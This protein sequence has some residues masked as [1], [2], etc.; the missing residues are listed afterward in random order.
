MSSLHQRAAALT[1]AAVALLAPQA[2][3]DLKI[4]E[5]LQASLEN[6][7]Q[8]RIAG[9]RVLAARGQLDRAR[10][11]FYPTINLSL[12]ANATPY[13]NRR[14]DWNTTSASMALT[15]PLLNPSAIPQRALAEHNLEAEQHSAVEAQRQ[16]AYTTARAFIQ[17][18]ASD[19]V[20]K[21]AESRF[22]RAKINFENADARAKAQLNSINDATRARVEM[23]TAAQSMAQGRA[24]RL[25]S[26]VQLGLLMGRPPPDK[27][28]PPDA[29]SESA[30]NF[31]GEADRLTR[32][33]IDN[34]PDLRALREQIRSAEISANEPRYR[35]IPSVNLGL[36]FR[37]NTDPFLAERLVDQ[38]LSLSLQWQIFD[39]GARYA[40]RRTRLAQAESLRLQQQLEFRTV[41]AEVQ[42]ALLL[43]EAAKQSLQAAE[44]GV[45]AAKVNTEETAILYQQGLARAIEV[46]DANARRFDAE[47]SLASARQL[48]MEAFLQ[49]REVL[50]LPPTD[51]LSMPAASGSSRHAP[52]SN[53]ESTKEP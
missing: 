15:Q 9:Q 18:L 24:S 20:F 25:Q 37:V 41:K 42:G 8:S 4:E 38:T 51:N 46:M 29:L 43:L 33:A 2:R 17:A 52:P 45:A 21:A 23:T 39:G 40:D 16:L 26:L 14:G 48:L 5:A 10:A 3:A 1:V 13:R 34:R 31:R 22:E 47:V 30:K 27:L 19:R 44:E 49:L 32:S 35:M 50:G 11:A 12:G 53:L 6:H 28:E 36:Q 7:E